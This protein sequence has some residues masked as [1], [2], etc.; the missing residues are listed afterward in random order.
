MYI[1][2]KGKVNLDIPANDRIKRQ[3]LDS[4]YARTYRSNA[5]LKML[6]NLGIYCTN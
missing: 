2:S 6:Y 5:E 3:G 1:Y 4:F